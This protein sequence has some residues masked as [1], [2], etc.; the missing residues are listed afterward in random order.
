MHLFKL[1]F[2]S[3]KTEHSCITFVWK[4]LATLQTIAM[5]FVYTF[6]AK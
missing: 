6:M 3:I 4:L 1:D 2:L 5:N